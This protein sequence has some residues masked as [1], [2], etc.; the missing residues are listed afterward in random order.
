MKYTELTKEDITTLI[1]RKSISCD[2]GLWTIRFYKRYVMCK[3]GEFLK[4]DDL[5]I[6]FREDVVEECHF[7]NKKQIH[8]KF[9][10]QLRTKN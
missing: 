10:S 6:M 7:D 2:N 9:I 3:D 5:L 1:E 4:N 8:N